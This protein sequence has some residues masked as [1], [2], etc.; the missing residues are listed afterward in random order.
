MKKLLVLI[1]GMVVLLTTVK[2]T[3][4]QSNFIIN[5]EDAV[6]YGSRSGEL[7]KKEVRIVNS[8]LNQYEKTLWKN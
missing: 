1:V 7:I 5:N 6:Y 8:E 3:S 2:A 4:E